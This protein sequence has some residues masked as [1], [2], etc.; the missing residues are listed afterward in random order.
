MNTDTPHDLIIFGEDWGSLPKLDS[1]E[2]FE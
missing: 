1:D 2:S